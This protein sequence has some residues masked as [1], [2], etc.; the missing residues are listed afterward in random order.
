MLLCMMIDRCQILICLFSRCLD[1]LLLVPLQTTRSF[2]M[3]CFNR[4][5]GLIG[6]CWWALRHV[7]SNTTCPERLSAT[8]ALSTPT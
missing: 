6:V 4:L 1:L 3:T 8:S 2:A 5:K 7:E